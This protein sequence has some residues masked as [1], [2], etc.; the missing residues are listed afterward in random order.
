MDKR[1]YYYEWSDSEDET[2]DETP[3]ESD[4]EFIDDSDASE[5]SDEDSEWFP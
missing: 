3:T 1:S 4:I 2:E 5:I